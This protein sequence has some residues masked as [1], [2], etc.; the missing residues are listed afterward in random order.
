MSYS[1]WRRNSG[2]RQGAAATKAVGLT[3]RVACDG[4]DG[5]RATE[6]VKESRDQAEE[7]PKA[8]G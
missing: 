3:A 5:R 4:G 6:E 8:V 2:D 1:S 7:V